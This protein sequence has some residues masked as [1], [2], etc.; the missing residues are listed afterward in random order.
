EP[1][2]AVTASCSPTASMYMF[3]LTNSHPVVSWTPP[4]SN[5]RVDNPFR[6]LAGRGA[7]EHSVVRADIFGMQSFVSLLAFVGLAVAVPTP[8]GNPDIEATKAPCHPTPV[9]TYTAT[10]L[11]HTLVPTPPYLIEETTLVEWTQS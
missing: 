9:G 1:A 3:T 6:V 5:L 4:T 11:I 10:R 2:N 8:S 7:G